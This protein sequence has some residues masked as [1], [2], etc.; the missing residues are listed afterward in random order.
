ML[1]ATSAYSQDIHFSQIFNSPLNLNPANTGAYNSDYRLVL[2][3]RNQWNSFT[4]AYSTMSA[5]FEYKRKS[6]IKL[7]DNAGIGFLINNDRAGDGNLATTGFHIP[8]AGTRKFLDSN[9]ELSAGIM[10]GF[11]QLSIDFNNFYFGT[12][13][14]GNVYNPD[15]PSYES[16]EQEK[17][18]YFDLSAGV[19]ASYNIN[20]FK[21][22]SGISLY[23]L[24]QPSVSF[25]LSPS[26]M[27]SLQSTYMMVNYAANSIYNLSFSYINRMQGSYRE[28]LFGSLVTIRNNNVLFHSFSA[29]VFFRNKDAVILMTHI[30]VNDIQIGLSYDINISE[31]SNASK[32]RGGFEFSL[33]YLMSFTKPSFYYPPK[34]CPDFI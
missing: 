16:L 34:P 23:H 19:S 4:N 26:I 5:S 11:N 21:I 10:A 33:I 6:K 7:L 20:K 32:G 1:S 22:T 27:R 25:L 8:I 24:N 28:N 30:N 3:H 18:I 14:D 12:Q 17:F 2:N 29:G 13:F 31:L 9:L 15:L